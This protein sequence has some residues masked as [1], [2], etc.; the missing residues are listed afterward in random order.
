MEEHRLRWGARPSKPSGRLTASGGF[1]SY[2]FRHYVYEQLT[3]VV[4]V[5][6]CS[7]TWCRSS[8][9]VIFDERRYAKAMTADT[10]GDRTLLTAS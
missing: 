3:Y 2:L 10:F 6:A 8:Q 9:R 4:L 5:W 1:D 7:C